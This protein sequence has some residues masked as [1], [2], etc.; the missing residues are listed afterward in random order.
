[1]QM[2]GNDFIVE[3]MKP[4][5]SKALLPLIKQPL[6]WMICLVMLNKRHHKEKLFSAELLISGDEPISLRV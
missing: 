2:T 6:I 1:M 4:M 3:K 5:K